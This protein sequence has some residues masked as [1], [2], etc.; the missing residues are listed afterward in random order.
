[1]L[2]P[3]YF[4]TQNAAFDAQRQPVFGFNFQPPSQQIGF[5]IGADG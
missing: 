3:S 1:M 5:A 2:D 4:S